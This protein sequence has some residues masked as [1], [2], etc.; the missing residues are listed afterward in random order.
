MKWIAFLLGMIPAVASA[1]CGPAAAIADYLRE[2]FGERPQFTFVSDTTIFTFYAG[3][4]SWSL[5]GVQ[6]EVACLLAEGKAWKY[7]GT[8]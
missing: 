1:N 2:K 6:G 4:K 8:L 5:I 7:N 3:D